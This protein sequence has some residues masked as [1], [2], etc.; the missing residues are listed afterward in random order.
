M[1]TSSFPDKKSR[2]RRE[3]LSKG[4]HAV[5]GL[6]TRSTEG[7]M[8]WGWQCQAR[9]QVPQPLAKVFPIHLYFAVGE[10][11]IKLERNV[12]WFFGMKNLLGNVLEIRC[13]DQ[14]IWCYNCMSKQSS[15]RFSTVE[16]N[17][18]SQAWHLPIVGISHKFLRCD[19][20]GWGN[21][22]KVWAAL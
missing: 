13:I 4:V 22:L 20:R 6:L 16:E 12:C 11:S 19:N 3:L 18:S 7:K 17:P 1:E 21:F 10:E 15:P 9:T 8:C 2:S 14:L 5:K